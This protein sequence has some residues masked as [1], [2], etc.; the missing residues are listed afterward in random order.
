M[1]TALKILFSGNFDEPADIT[2]PPLV[3]AAAHDNKKF[4]LKRTEIVSLFN[5]F[6]RLSTSIFSLE[7]FRDQLR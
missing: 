6:G 1:G 3:P 4:K 7:A 5:A 2:K